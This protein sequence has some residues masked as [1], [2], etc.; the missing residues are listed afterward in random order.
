MTASQEIVP[1]FARMGL[2]Y[3]HLIACCLAIALVL[4]NDFAAVKDLVRADADS[5]WAHR[6]DMSGLQAAVLKALLALW[7]TGA[8]LVTLDVKF[9]GGWKH[10]ENPKLQA[11]ILIVVLLT[12]NGAVLHRFVLPWLQEAGALLHLPP[13]KMA[14]AQFSGVVS[15]VS[16]LYAAM[17]GTARPLAWKYSL[18]DLMVAYPLLIAAGF[19]GMLA[20][21][22]WSSHR[23]KARTRRKYWHGGRR[24]V[25]SFR[26]SR[27][28]GLQ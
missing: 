5:R 26:R 4:S 1:V 7:V 17:L 10:F 9:D 27:P 11:K 18:S 22:A 28:L 16:W 24:P 25:A 3:L 2:V 23:N 20:L 8:T 21:T 14:L 13:G 15:G 6:S 19:A 12:L